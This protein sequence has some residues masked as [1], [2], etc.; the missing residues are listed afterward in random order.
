MH[1]SEKIV[2]CY[3]T[4]RVCSSS[5]IFSW[6]GLL[7]YRKSR[8]Q[9]GGA[10]AGAATQALALEALA[11]VIGKLKEPVTLH[12]ISSP[13]LPLSIIKAA[14]DLRQGFSIIPVIGPVPCSL[15]TEVISI[16]AF[17]MQ[18]MSGELSSLA[19][20]ALDVFGI[21]EGSVAFEEVGND[22]S[23]FDCQKRFL[24]SAAA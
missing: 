5:G 3:F 21:E 23:R 9:L 1:P 4:S 17:A 18:S 19:L 16:E 2:Q 20:M 8:L 10:K 13:E 11:E 7:E 15:T 22:C 24:T 14:R 12:L 6:A